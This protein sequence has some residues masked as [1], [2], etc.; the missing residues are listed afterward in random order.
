M[1]CRLEFIKSTFDEKSAKKVT[2]QFQK[3]K[4]ISDNRWPKETETT[5]QLCLPCIQHCIVVL[6]LRPGPTL[7]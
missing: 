2:N 1:N 5:L 4:H 7:S 3:S 6:M